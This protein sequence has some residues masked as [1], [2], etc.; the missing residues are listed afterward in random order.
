MTSLTKLDLGRNSIRVVEGI[1]QLVNLRELLLGHNQ[2]CAY[3][4]YTSRRMGQTAGR[5]NASV[6]GHL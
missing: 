2:M 4:T 5:V 6:G 3:S 1:E